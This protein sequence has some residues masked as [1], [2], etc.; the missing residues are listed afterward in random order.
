MKHKIK[1]TV[2][3]TAMA[4]AVMHI[5]NKF[6]SSAALL[7][8]LLNAKTGKYF[9]WRF[10]RIFYTKSG[11][12]TPLLL[13]HDLTPFSSSYEW[14][15]VIKKLSKQ[16]TV[17]AIDL[18][19]CGRSDKPNMTYTNFLYVQLVSDFIKKIIG[20]KTDVI[21]T[22]FS[23]SFVVMACHNDANNFNKI[24]MVNPNKLSKLNSIPGKRSK[25]T[26][27]LMDLPIIGT[28]LYNMLVNK[29]SLEYI[30]T[31]QYIYNPFRLQQKYIDVFYESAHLSEGGGKY[32][33]SSIN[34][35]YLNT[36]IIHA[37]K[38]INNSIFIIAGS[39][40]SDMEDTISSYMELNPAIETAYVKDTKI[41]PHIESADI[42]LEQ[43]SVFF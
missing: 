23:S 32:L 24:F 7:K 34:G 25:V 2:I 11:Q 33:L 29:N 27:I 36:N 31:E 4:I 18:L 42:F 14:N 10:G 38:E 35:L 6:I 22:G 1:T 8:N 28:M 19:G 15:E 39:K 13:I 40:C 17:Y 41:L 21:A 26:K 9:D 30:F 16:H 43:I 3:L 20:Q 37:L 12:G 5:I